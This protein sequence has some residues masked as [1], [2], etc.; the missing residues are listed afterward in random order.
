VNV[1]KFISNT[2]TMRERI[3]MLADAAKR[4]GPQQAGFMFKGIADPDTILMLT[5]GREAV[6][7]LIAK[8]AELG[9]VNENDAKQAQERQ[10]VWREL[11]ITFTRTADVLLNELSP[12]IVTVMKNVS[13]WTVK[14]KEFINSGIVSSIK[15]IGSA[16]SDLWTL[17]GPILRLIGEGWHNIFTWV[18]AAA[19]EVRQYKESS[20]A[21]QARDGVDDSKLGRAT[22]HVLAFFGNDAARDALDLERRQLSSPAPASTGNKAPIAGTTSALFSSLEKQ[23]GLPTG[24]LDSMWQQE[25]GRGK[26]MTSPKGARGHFQF[27]PATAKEYGLDDPDDL[28]K[29]ALAAAKKMADLLKQFG[30]L[31]KALAAY[32]WGDGRVARNGLNGAPLETLNYIKGIKSRLPGTGGNVTT[33]DVKID[34]ITVN[35]QATDAA[36]IARDID[37]ALKQYLVGSQNNFALQ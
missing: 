33:N 20:A 24:L 2:T 35:S 6:E 8:G 36:G 16:V 22:A 12:A 19:D 10:R 3:L 5:Q 21:K 25:S 32:N 9:V 28:A 13:D 27:M 31:D 29:S 26:N 37:P 14:N 11:S 23:F 17:A 7:A 34:R 4:M 18:H 30:G 1:G 15:E